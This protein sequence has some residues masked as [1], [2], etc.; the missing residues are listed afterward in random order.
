MRPI[1]AAIVAMLVGCAAPPATVQPQA[2][3]APAR[4]DL[5]RAMASTPFARVLA[6][7]AA[8][9][10]TLRR[11]AG[12]PAF[13]NVHDRMETNTLDVDRRLQ[14]A[15]ARV[16]NLRAQSISAMPAAATR[17]DFSDGMVGAFAQAAQSRVARA[18]GLRAAQLREH[19]ATVAYD[20]ERA[21]AG[22]RLVLGLKLRDLHLDAPTRH[23]YQTQL[24]ALDRQEAVVVGAE[25]ERDDAVLS[26]YAVNLRSQASADTASMGSDLAE[27]ARAMRTIPQPQMGT[28]PSSLLHPVDARAPMLAAFADARRDLT[29]R[30]H[31]LQAANGVANGDVAREIATLERERDVLRAQIVASIETRAARIAA[32]QHLGRVYTH[33]APRAARDITDDVLRSYSVSTGS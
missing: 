8:D 25:R 7:Y 24:D 23:R 4:I 26:A 18:L 28:L 22:R 5:Q 16:A 30:L 9:I 21:H 32:A 17:R 29:A 10:A 2:A 3:G 6:Q 15:S 12:D 14:S 27:H 33:K 31:E 19:E 20:F 13:A 1:V 11:A